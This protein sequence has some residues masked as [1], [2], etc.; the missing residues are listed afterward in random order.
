[1]TDLVERMREELRAE[2]H[3]R[4]WIALHEA[5]HEKYARR[6]GAIDIKYEGPQE[7]PGRPGEYGPAGIKQVFPPSGARMDALTMAHWYCAGAVMQ[8]VLAPASWEE[9]AD[10]TDYAIFG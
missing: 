7:Y 1:M 3:R 4:L 6:A 9:E 2:P 5:G 10:A 8:K